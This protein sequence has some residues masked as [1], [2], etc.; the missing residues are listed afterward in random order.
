[1]INQIF[2]EKTEKSGFM[3]LN[4]FFVFLLKMKEV[5]VARLVALLVVRWTF[6]WLSDVFGIL[7]HE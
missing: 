5:V 4:R 3:I 7:D 2:I 1:M 6:C